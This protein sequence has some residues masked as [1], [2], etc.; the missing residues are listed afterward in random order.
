[1][2]PLIRRTHFPFA[3]FCV[4]LFLWGQSVSLGWLPYEGGI[5]RSSVLLLG[6]TT[7][8]LAQGR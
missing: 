2:H 4:G 1:M 3:V 5:R 6:W 7:L 8:E